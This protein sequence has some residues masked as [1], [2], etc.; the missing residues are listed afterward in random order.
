[1]QKTVVRREKVEN[2]FFTGLLPAHLR[3]LAL[4]TISKD[5]VYMSKEYLIISVVR[6]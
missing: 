5:M 2:I 4:Y 6:F 1:M 3:V